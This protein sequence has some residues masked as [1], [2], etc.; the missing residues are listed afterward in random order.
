MF[1][2]GRRSNLPP[3]Q[4]CLCSYMALRRSK[5]IPSDR[6]NRV[7]LYAYAGVIPLAD[8]KLG[9]GITL[10][11]G[12][13]VPFESFGSVGHNAEAKVVIEREIELAFGTALIGSNTV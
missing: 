12:Q 7:L 4:L 9:F 11:G 2:L 5:P 13:S 3:D 6:L 8:D 10:P 1:E